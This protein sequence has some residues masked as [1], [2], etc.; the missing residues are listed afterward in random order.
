M[1]ICNAHY[2]VFAAPASAQTLLK[3]EQKLQMV[4]AS[5]LQT[6]NDENCC[7]MQIVYVRNFLLNIR[8]ET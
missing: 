5:F 8:F 2:R 1:T 4:W 3:N 6:F 7:K